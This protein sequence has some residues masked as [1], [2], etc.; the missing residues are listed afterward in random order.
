MDSVAARRRLLASLL[1]V[2]PGILSGYM[3][4]RRA[5]FG[6]LYKPVSL[7]KNQVL[8]E[9]VYR[10]GSAD[11]KHRLDLFLPEGTQWPI[12]VFVHG[13]GLNSG[14]KALRVAGSD[15]YGNIGRFYANHGIG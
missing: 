10:E 4:V 12:L 2:G 8:R 9:V 13:G 5:V 14:D 1:L 7:P 15:V 3:M 11:S 6:T